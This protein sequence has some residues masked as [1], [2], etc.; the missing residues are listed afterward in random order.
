MGE[1][2]HSPLFR[3]LRD[4][5][6]VGSITSV[7]LSPRTGGVLLGIL[8]HELVL[9]GNRHALG[10]SRRRSRIHVLRH[11]LLREICSMGLSLSLGVM[12]L[13]LLR[14]LLSRLL[15]G[16]GIG[17]C[18]RSHGSGRRDGVGH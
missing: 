12:G 2:R 5:R 7:Y 3:Y 8:R 14:W 13:L 15:V 18:R 11:T 17:V 16:V 4:A 6:I 10:L 9:L 1:N